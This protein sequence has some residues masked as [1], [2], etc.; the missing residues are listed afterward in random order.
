MSELDVGVLKL[1]SIVKWMKAI[2]QI[3][4]ILNALIY[5]GLTHHSELMCLCSE[6]IQEP[7]I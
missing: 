4:L 6:C 3:P 7:F 5:N 1:N 2:V